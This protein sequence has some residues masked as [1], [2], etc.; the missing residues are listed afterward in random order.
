MALPVNRQ[1]RR[2]R[3]SPPILGFGPWTAQSAGT[4]LLQRVLPVDGTTVAAVNGR[5]ASTRLRAIAI[6]SS[7]LFWCMA[8]LS[9]VSGTVLADPLL[10]P[11]QEGGVLGPSYRLSQD[12]TRVVELTNLDSSEDCHLTRLV[13]TVVKRQFDED[14]AVVMTGVT[15]ELADGRRQFSYIYVEL[16]AL[17]FLDRDWVLTGLQTLLKEGNKAD[18]GINLCGAGGRIAVLNSVRLA[19]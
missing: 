14:R 3:P 5:N 9:F 10:E 12:R 18:L 19:H 2:G 8:T 4:K 11:T 15:V 13:G 1:F 16:T 7:S 17:S 6:I